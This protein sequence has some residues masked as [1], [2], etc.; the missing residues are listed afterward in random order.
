MA[1]PWLG[2]K[3]SADKAKLACPAKARRAAQARRIAAGLMEA[4][5]GG[6]GARRKPGGGFPFRAG[7]LRIDEGGSGK[8][9]GKG[10]KRR[11]AHLSP[12]SVVKSGDEVFGLFGRS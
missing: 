7:F 3:G 6:G 9:S 12:Q 2:L 5:L 11:H 10:I 8:L 1:M 4:T